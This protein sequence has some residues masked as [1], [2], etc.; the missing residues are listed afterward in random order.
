MRQIHR[1]NA[2]EPA[3]RF[4]DFLVTK[5]IS[6]HAEQ[7]HDQWAIWVRDEDQLEKA[8]GELSLFLQDPDDARYA[9][10]QQEART[11]RQQELD[12]RKDA[13]RNMIDMR[14]RWNRPITRQAPL[15]ATI[16]GICIAVALITNFQTTSRVSR[17]LGACDP[18]VLAESGN[19]W[20]Q[21]SQGQVWRL[22]TPNLLHGGMI[23]L[24]F[25]MAFLWAIGSQIEFRKGS[26]FL[27]LLI[28][29]TGTMAIAFQ[30]LVLPNSFPVGMSG[31]GYGL[32]GYV[33]MKSWYDPRSTFVI[34]P[35]TI[36][37][38]MGWFFLCFTGSLGSIANWAHAGG[39]V[40]GLL[41]GYLPVHF[42]LS[43]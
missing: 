42:R 26:P 19:S 20:T 34:S 1:F 4:A 18:V 22:F 36:A 43:K 38:I 29:A 17:L 7:D 2:L 8:R 25:N 41:I 39:L 13:A 30:L 24:A 27:A 35:Q 6:A 23:H 3:T 9:Q 31:A 33:W 5:G 12:R 40:A 14:H 32:F 37:I 28:V 11:I 16:I 15:T 21:I 10:A